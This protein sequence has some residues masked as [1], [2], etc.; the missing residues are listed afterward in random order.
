MLDIGSGLGVDSFISCHYVGEKGKVIGLDI[1]KNEVKHATER[2][3]VRG[4]DMRFVTADMED[5]PLPDSMLDV[6]ISNGA[7]CLAPNKEKA[8]KEIFRVLKPGGR[9]CIATS[10]VKMDLQPGVHWPICMRMFIHIDK[11]VP[12]CEEIGFTQVKVDDTNSLM[13]YDLPTDEAGTKFEPSGENGQIIPNEEN[14]LNP[15][16]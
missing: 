13:Q 2:A 16:R 3:S 8:F 4:L 11:L 7:F 15:D 14:E 6:V 12:M 9:M 5:I 10:T 1:S